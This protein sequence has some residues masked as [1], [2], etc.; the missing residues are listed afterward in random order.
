MR[1]KLS[2]S[3]KIKCDLLIVGAGVTGAAIAF[4]TAMFSN[5]LHII[6]IEQ[7]KDA[8][9]VNSNPNNN[10]QTSHEGD[11]ETNYILKKA[12][13]VKFAATLLRKYVVKKATEGLYKVTNRMVL[14]VGAKEVKELEDRFA[15]FSEHYPHLKLIR[16]EEIGN[17]E[18]KVM[19][20]RD[21]KEAVAALTTDQGF[22][23]NYQILARELLNDAK[24]VEGKKVEVMFETKLETIKKVENNY[25][26]EVLQGESETKMTIEAEVVEFAAGP[27]S[28]RFAQLLG[29]ALN[30]AIMNVAASFYHAG[31]FLLGKVYRNQIPNIPFAALHGD[32]SVVDGSSQ[33]GPTTKFVPLMERHHYDTFGDYMKTP[34][35]ST[36]KGY[37]SFWRTLRKNHLLLYGIKNYIFDIPL[38][39]KYLF[40]REVRKIIPSLKWSDLRLLKNHGGIRPQIID[41]DAENPLVMGDSNIVG[42]K[43]IFNTTPSPGASVC[44]KNSYRDLNKIIE[45]FGGKYYFDKEAFKEWFEVTDEEIEAAFTD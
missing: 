40:W 30:L 29:Y 1:K 5:I 14:G 38:I 16:G 43:I 34:L 45:F 10:S 35:L 25:V 4:M 8:G 15:E 3:Q 12:L 20:A 6:V 23:I 19:E 42:D 27:Y 26:I 24:T 44:L 18:P 17:L 7:Y 31:T 33:F 22:A 28:L 11:T 32:K 39:G 41:M 37:F 2:K 21:P 36:I 13:K 9:M